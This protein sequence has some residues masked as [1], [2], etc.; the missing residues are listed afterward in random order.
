MRSERSGKLQA[1]FVF[2]QAQIRCLFLGSTV[3]PVPSLHPVPRTESVRW[4]ASLFFY[5]VRLLISD[6]EPPDPGLFTLSTCPLGLL[7][8]LST[9]VSFV[10]RVYLACRSKIISRISHARRTVDRESSG[11]GSPAVQLFGNLRFGVPRAR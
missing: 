7:V 5:L 3:Y 11:D 6:F 8:L 9:L 2:H 1:C 4:G 10:S